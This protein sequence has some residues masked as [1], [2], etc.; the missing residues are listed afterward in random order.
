MKMQTTLLYRG[1]VEG[2]IKGLDACVKE[3]MKDCVRLWH[4]LFLP[5]HFDTLNA[6]RSRYPNVYKARTKNYMIRK[7][8]VHKHQRLLDWS[9]RTRLE[10]LRK[11]TVT[12]TSKGATGRMSGSNRAL[13]FS[14]RADMPNMRA[15]ITTVNQAESNV[16]AQALGQ[17]IEAFMNSVEQTRTVRPDGTSSESGSADV[18]VGRRGGRYTV[19]DSGR[20]VYQK[21]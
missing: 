21:R 20:R 12:G 8:K 3:S 1:P 18:Q 15:E 13:N 17:G 4:G 9:G 14:G 2:K 10:M 16:L 19:N 6:V 7:G 5:G 11:I